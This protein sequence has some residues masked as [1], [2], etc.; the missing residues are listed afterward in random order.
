MNIWLFH[1]IHNLFLDQLQ[2]LKY[3]DLTMFIFKIYSVLSTK[4][5]FFVFLTFYNK[6]MSFSTDFVKSLWYVKQ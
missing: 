2:R 6:L 4:N 3:I 1:T 5:I